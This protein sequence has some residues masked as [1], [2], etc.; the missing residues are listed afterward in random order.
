M[1]VTADFP[2][3]KVRA[4][5]RVKAAMSACEI[6]AVRTPYSIQERTVARHASRLDALVNDCVEYLQ[7]DG[8]SARPKKYGS[9]TVE[10]IIARPFVQADAPRILEC[11]REYIVVAMRSTTLMRRQ[12]VPFVMDYH[13][14]T[15]LIEPECIFTA[16]VSTGSS[17]IKLHVECA[18]RNDNPP[19]F[20]I[21]TF[22]SAASTWYY[23]LNGCA[24]QANREGSSCL[25]TRLD[26]SRRLV[27]DSNNGFRSAGTFNSCDINS[28]I[29]VQ[30]GEDA[31]FG[32]LDFDCVM[33]LFHCE[34]TRIA[35]QL[36]PPSK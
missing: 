1:V 6:V 15:L 20:D 5:R 31:S 9:Y 29:I 10:E 28:K 27:F 18:D 36:L 35:P 23:T 33:D 14:Y 11:V 21:N 22:L 34:L 3:V 4:S 32:E 24:K 7:T 25:D 30:L 17:T 8:K 16:T 13:E 19:I 2:Q 26:S 12:R